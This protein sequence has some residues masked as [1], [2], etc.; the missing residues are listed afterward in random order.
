M[1][2]VIK[3]MRKIFFPV[4]I[5]LS[6]CLQAKVKQ[7]GGYPITPVPFTAVKVTDAFLGPTAQGKS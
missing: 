5:C 3:S 7:P 4:L 6:I 2:N 1:V